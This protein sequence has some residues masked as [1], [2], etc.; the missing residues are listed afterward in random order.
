MCLSSKE[1]FKPCKTGYKIMMKVKRGLIGEFQGLYNYR[2]M[3]K[4]LDEKNYRSL[5]TSAHIPLPSG[6]LY[7]TGWHIYHG[8]RVALQHLK[9]YRSVRSNYV[10]VKV[11]VRTPLLTGLQYCFVRGNHINYLRVTVAKEIRIDSIL[12]LDKDKR[13]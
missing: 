11:S 8:K 4:W 13:R 6:E 7:P 1:T 3:G 12:E 5:P 9:V 2:P 10:L